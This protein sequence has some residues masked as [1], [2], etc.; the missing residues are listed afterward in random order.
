MTAQVDH[1]SQNWTLISKPNSILSTVWQNS[2][3]FN[4]TFWHKFDI[5]NEM[6]FIIF[7]MVPATHPINCQMM[8]TY[9]LMSLL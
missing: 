9:F 3:N 7:A 6:L 4:S 2:R 8:Q 1:D 5:N